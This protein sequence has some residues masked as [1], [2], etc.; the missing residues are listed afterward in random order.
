MKS[1][2]LATALVGAMLSSF[3]LAQ[4]PTAEQKAAIT[5]EIVKVY[6]PTPHPQRGI[7]YW[8][9]DSR[10]LVVKNVSSG[11]TTYYFVDFTRDRPALAKIKSYDHTG[12]GAYTH[13]YRP[14]PQHPAT[15]FEVG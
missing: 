13:Q 12:K 9:P 6:A 10:T 1:L 8:E 11:A 4:E 7:D 3:V 15:A 2:K 5:L 14:R